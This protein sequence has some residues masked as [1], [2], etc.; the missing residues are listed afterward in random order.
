MLFGDI[1]LHRQGRIAEAAVV[2]SVY[3]YGITFA[4][5]LFVSWFVLGYKGYL[6]EGRKPSLLTKVWA[7]S[8]FDFFIKVRHTA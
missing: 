6:F 8:W 4:V 5:R 7:V 2:A 3:T 1:D